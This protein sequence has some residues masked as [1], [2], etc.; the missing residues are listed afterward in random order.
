[1]P[2]GLTFRGDFIQNHMFVLL[3]GRLNCH[4]FAI[5]YKSTAMIIPHYF[6]AILCTL[7]LWVETPEAPKPVVQEKL[8]AITH[9][10]PLLDVLPDLL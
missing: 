1:M 7:L 9:L 2:G 3:S 5:Y 4:S 6:G 10:H 8:P